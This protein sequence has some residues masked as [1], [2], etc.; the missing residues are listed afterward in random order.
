MLSCKAEEQ[1]NRHE[2]QHHWILG[3]FYQVFARCDWMYC[4]HDL[5]NEELITMCSR[6]KPSKVACNIRNLLCWIPKLPA[7]AASEIFPGACHNHSPAQP[8]VTVLVFGTPVLSSGPFYFLGFDEVQFDTETN[9]TFLIHIY[10][11]AKAEYSRKPQ[12]FSTFLDG[13]TLDCWVY[14]KPRPFSSLSMTGRD[15]P[16]KGRFPC[17]SILHNASMQESFKN[18]PH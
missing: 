6:E 2:P 4:Y 13:R 9:F 14:F 5:T 15:E 18:P 8:W 7:P 1:E 17:F 11:S 12:L 3:L 10:S 16:E